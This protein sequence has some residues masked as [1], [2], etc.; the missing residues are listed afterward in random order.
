MLETFFAAG[1]APDTPDASGA[2]ALH[3]AAQA[4]RGE[5]VT[6]L[7]AQGADPNRVSGE[8]WSPLLLAA[9]FGRDTVVTELL[10]YAADPGASNPDG[11]LALHLAAAK[12]HLS[13]LDALLAAGVSIDQRSPEG[14]TAL[15][16]VAVTP[17]LEAAAHLLARGADPMARGGDHQTPLHVT[18]FGFDRG[19]EMATLLLDA[20]AE[21]D[22]TNK[23]RATALLLA[24]QQGNRGV[25]QALLGRGANPELRSVGGRTALEAARAADQEDAAKLLEGIADH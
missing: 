18:A 16:A 3:A 20:G 7:L 21:I 25:I 9:L 19:R 14:A 12:G 24:A 2:T 6:L 4:G 15:H 10:S 22:A 17:Q 8:G 11:Q 23:H 5:T 13:T 1:V